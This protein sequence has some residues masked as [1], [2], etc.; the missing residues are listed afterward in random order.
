MN[1][2]CEWPMQ[3]GKQCTGDTGLMRCK[4]EHGNIVMKPTPYCFLHTMMEVKMWNIDE[5][6]VLHV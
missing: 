6:E 4:D 5:Q 2:K 3:D 1:G